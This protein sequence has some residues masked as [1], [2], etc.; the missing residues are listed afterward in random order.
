MC[1]HWNCTKCVVV[2]PNSWIN[3]EDQFLAFWQ[4]PLVGPWFGLGSGPPQSIG[5]RV[6]PSSITLFPLS[7]RNRTFLARI[8][9]SSRLGRVFV[10][11]GEVT[12]WHALAVN[13]ICILSFVYVL[14]VSATGHSLYCARQQFPSNRPGKRSLR[15]TVPMPRRNPTVNGILPSTNSLSGP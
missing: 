4:T 3:F 5:S 7:R 13:N 8:L 12:A 1:Y 14:Y 10:Q 2:E 6:S 11:N 15:E 9:R